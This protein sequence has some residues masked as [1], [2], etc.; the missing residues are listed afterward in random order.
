MESVY[1]SIIQSQNNKEQIRQALV[2][3]ILQTISTSKKELIQLIEIGNTISLYITI[4]GQLNNINNPFY[5]IIL[6][7][8]FFI[9]SNSIL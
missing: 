2:D 8:S 6:C 1:Q 4:N 7:G 5:N 3:K 9:Y